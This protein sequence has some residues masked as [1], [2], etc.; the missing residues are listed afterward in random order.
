VQPDVFPEVT[1]VSVKDG[2]RVEG[3]MEDRAAKY[4]ADQNHLLVNGDFRVFKDLI[5]HFM[6]NHKGIAGAEAVVTNAVRGWFAQA[7]VEAV[8]GVQALRNSKEWVQ[9]EIERALS[10]EALTA[11]TMQRYHVHLAVKRE[12]GAKFGSAKQTAA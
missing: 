2:S 6:R 4:L 8:I 7:L 11:C 9:D 10:E 1:W 3:D 12:L 5:A